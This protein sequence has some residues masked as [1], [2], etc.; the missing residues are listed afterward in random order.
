MEKSKILS[1]VGIIIGVAIFVCLIIIYSPTSTETD[2]P[3]PPVEVEKPRVTEAPLD[4]RTDIREGT[5][6]MPP[7]PENPLSVPSMVALSKQ[8]TEPDATAEDDLDVVRSLI[9]YYRKQNRIAPP[10]GL[11]EEIVAG[12]R[13]N[14][15]RKLRL[16][17]DSHPKLSPSGELLDRYGTPYYLH[18]LS[19]KMIEIRS[20]GPDKKLWTDDDIA[21]EDETGGQLSEKL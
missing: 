13:G 5:R 4:T 18:P 2:E 17:E 7:V 14:N 1:A 20:A 16:I 21:I 6:T 12:L 10:G 19:E 11:N 3:A 9:E 8:L 15:P